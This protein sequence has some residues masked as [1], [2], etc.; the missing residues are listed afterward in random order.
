[1]IMIGIIGAGPNAT[2]H[3]KYYASH[4]E[5]ARVVAVADVDA[6]R[7]KAL[8]EVCGAKPVSDFRS[9][10][11]DVDAVVIASPNFLHKDQAIEAAR[12]GKHV[13]C[14]KPMGL[15]LTD[16]REIEAAVRLAKVQS[17]VGFAVRFDPQI[18]TMARMAASGDFG[19]LISVASRRLMWMDHSK[20]A[21]W[22]A[23]PAKSGGLLFEINIHELEWMM[24]VGG[25]VTAVHANIFKL[26]PHPR[27]NDHL[28]VNLRFASGTIGNHE[29]SWIASTPM[30][31][32][33]VVGTE[34]GAY[35]NEWGNIL[36]TAKAGQNRT[37][38]KPDPAYDLRGNFLDAIEGKAVPT[39]NCAYALKVMAV[40][41]AIIESANTNKVVTPEKVSSAPTVEAK[42]FTKPALV[43]Q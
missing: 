30:F 36:Y 32:R 6:D 10:L 12:A 5:R 28:T 14:E 13:Y 16:A 24:Y 42:V 29:G 8:A 37:E 34:A 35:T 23:D 7:A 4:P 25:D 27:A 9:F 40:A 33:Q 1:M 26:S 41:E 2:G 38:I 18:Q 20:T 17:Q 43:T 3:G 39:A 11:S 22:R 31:W 19:P 15:S 21:G